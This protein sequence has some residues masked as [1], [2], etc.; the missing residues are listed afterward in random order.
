MKSATRE[1]IILLEK[2]MK[3]L[4]DINNKYLKEKKN[5]EMQYFLG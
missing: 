5:L 1:D 4:S 3:E 2:R